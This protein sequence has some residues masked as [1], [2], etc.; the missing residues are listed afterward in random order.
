M[1]FVCLHLPGLG[2]GIPRD[3]KGQVTVNH[4]SNPGERACDLPTDSHMT[5][6]GTGG[7]LI[8]SPISVCCVLAN[9]DLTVN[10]IDKI[11][12]LTF[13]VN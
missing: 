10:Q 6:K 4:M 9:A 1:G 2:G 8:G 3:S 5:E 13:S 7:A 11:L 12:L